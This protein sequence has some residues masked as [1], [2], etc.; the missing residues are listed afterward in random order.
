MAYRIALLYVAWT[1]LGSA[2]VLGDTVGPV[3][4]AV[5]VEFE[6][7]PF[8][9]KHVD[10]DG[11][12]V[13]GSTQVSDAALYEAAWILR[14]MLDGR[15][16][17]LRAMAGRNVHLVVMAWNEFTTDVPEHSHLEPKVYWDRRA[18]G[19]GGSPVSCAEENLLAHPG[20]PY[21]KENILI[22]E[23][24]H[25]VHL[26][27]LRV[28]DPN[29]DARLK[30]AYEHAK[31]N[32]LWSGTYAITDRA[33]YWAEGVQCWFDNN[34]EN[35]ALHCHVNT[36]A[37]LKDYDPELAKLCA[38]VLGDGPWRYRKPM[39][40]EPARRA[41]LLGWDPAN[42]PYFCWRQAPLTEKPRVLIQTA[43][44]DI[45][46]ELDAQHA[47]VTTKNFLHYVLEGFYSDGVFFRT[48]TTSN[49]PDD[50]V[51]IAVIQAQADPA[52][53][54]E[55][56]APIAIERTCDTGLKHIEGTISMARAA[57]DSATHHFFI[58]VGDQPELDFGGRRN[59]DGQGFAAFG[60]VVKGMDVVR[61]I[62]AAPAEGQTLTPAVPIQRAVRVH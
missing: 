12:P 43:I 5:R 44:G 40:R 49:Q 8:Y 1:F 54:E 37:E 32:G 45:E 48:V 34:R 31:E 3:P 58:C 59:P 28:V 50:A 24:A 2:L 56:L 57:P 35:D 42:A 53:E 61:K 27:G 10:V 36:R 46:V 19:L 13:V 60:R 41:H 25:A 33:E 62:H 6:L 39:D 15:S 30:V 16:D 4:E 20:D 38:E 11:F 26:I 52:R 14:H 22:H 55:A 29:F 18:R 21:A 9:Q 51:K 7:G 17:I 47:P 23:F